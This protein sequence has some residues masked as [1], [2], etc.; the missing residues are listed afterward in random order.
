LSEYASSEFSISYES[1]TEDGLKNA[2]YYAMD[3][4]EKIEKMSIAAKHKS[5]ELDWDGIGEKVSKTYDDLVI[6]SVPSVS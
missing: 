5:L 4:K 6:N 1:S 2:I 3:T